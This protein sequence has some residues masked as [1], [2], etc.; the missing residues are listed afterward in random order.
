MLPLDWVA[1]NFYS[2]LSRPGSLEVDEASLFCR[3]QRLLGNR[4]FFPNVLRCTNPIIRHHSKVG[5]QYCDS[6]AGQPSQILVI[7]IANNVRSGLLY[8]SY[9]IASNLIVCHVAQHDCILQY[10]LYCTAKVIRLTGAEYTISFSSPWR[11]EL[12][13][14]HSS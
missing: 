2:E 12:I 13:Q 7:R 5:I 1:T 6:T 14:H 9:D 3:Q 11:L 10:L 8:Q 4:N